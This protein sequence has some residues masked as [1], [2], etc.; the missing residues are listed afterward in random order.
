MLRDSTLRT[1]LCGGAAVIAMVAAQAASAQTTIRAPIPAEEAGSA[2]TVQTSPISPAPTEAASAPSA[3]KPA[4]PA[5]QDATQLGT[6]VVTASKRPEFLKDV[7]SSIAVL[8]GLG[9]RKQGAARLEDYVARVPGLVLNAQSVGQQQITIR[10]LSTGPGGAPTVAVYMGEAPYGSSTSGGAGGLL[11][12]DIDVIDLERIEVL[13]GPQGTLYGASNI[14]GLLKYVL[15]APDTGEFGG[16]VGMEGSKA[17][18]GG[19]GYAVRGRVNVPI[20]QDQ[21]AI[22][23]SGYYR[24]DPGFVDDRGRGLTDVDKTRV[25][26]GRLSA[27]WTPSPGLKIKAEAIAQDRRARGFAEIDVDPA[28][29]TPVYGDYEQHRAVGADFFGSKMRQYILTGSYGFNGIEL[30]VTTSYNTLKDVGGADYTQTFGPIA[31]AFGPEFN[32]PDLG[33][34]AVNDIAQRKFSEEIRLSGKLAEAF[35]W[36]GGVFFSKETSDTAVTL[37]TFDSATGAALVLPALLVSDIQTN[38]T[39][40]AGFGEVTY[41]ATSKLDLIGGLRY[42]TNK[43]SNVST[44]SGALVGPESTVLSDSKDSSTT[45]SVSPRYKFN[46]NLMAYARVASGYRP[47]GAN[48]GYGPTPNYAP[49][50]VVN[51]EVGFKAGAPA[52][53]I[54]LDVAL[55]SIDWKQIQLLLRDSN[56]LSYIDNAGRARSQGVEAALSYSP[57]SGLTLAASAA[58]TDAKLR[59]DI[60]SGQYG[61]SGDSLP[62]SPK[63]KASVSADYS[64]VLGDNL[65]SFVGASYFYTDKVLAA[66]SA[67]AVTPRI[68]LPSFST[69]DLRVGVTLDQVR[70]GLFVKNVSDTRGYN[71]TRPLTLDAAGTASASLIQPRTLGVSLATSF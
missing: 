40:Y 61:L 34:S 53:K 12:P 39:E 1:D 22:L 16:E 70:V 63:L 42:A 7:P 29:L 65:R 36:T 4:S 66:F 10:G 43:Q 62:Y 19:A 50:T 15:I 71:G 30:T 60:P 21:F 25:Y 58:Y 52:K 9:L 45:F 6:V 41:H 8:D 11:T 24:R 51:Y 38:Y 20:V 64:F 68:G 13:R 31:T 18:H 57:V 35:D 28:T 54:Y 67:D 69:V 32:V 23:A 5:G 17:S 49:D 2:P 26:G 55:F 44:S 59:Q 46:P 33:F 3:A 48:G 47:G 27:L 14:G 37:P 56:G